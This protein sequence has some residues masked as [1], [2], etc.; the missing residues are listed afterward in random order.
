MILFDE[1]SKSFEKVKDSL[2]KIRTIYTPKPGD[3]LHT[4]SDWS[5][6]HGAAGGRLE[7][8]RNRDDGT[9]EKLHGGFY[10]AR[11]S[12]WQ[13][14]W[15][16]CEAECLSARLVLQHF[17]PQIQCSDQPVIH[18]TDSMPTFQAWKKAK[19]GA[20]SSSARIAAFLTEISD[21]NVEFVHTSGKNMNYSDYSSR[22]AV[23]CHEPNCQ[24]CSFVN[25]KVFVGDN[26]IRSIKVEDIEKGNV[27]MPYT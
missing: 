18:H 6:S 12:N 19:T 14:R 23:I 15:L 22:H 9:V 4:Y 10:S 5:Q 27:Q 1:L 21:L 26:V 24:I 11:V 16:P 7:V 13:Q 25:D 20:F 3:I 2:R 8:H 17:R